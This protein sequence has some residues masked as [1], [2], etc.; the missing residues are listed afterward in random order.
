M[1]HSLSLPPSVKD[2]GY[3]VE[4]FPKK[5]RL[6]FTHKKGEVGW[7][8]FYKR[9][10]ITHFHSSQTILILSFPECL[11]CVWFNTSKLFIH[12]NTG[13]CS[14][15]NNRQ[16]FLRVSLTNKSTIKCN[17]R[18]KKSWSD[19]KYFF[20]D[21]ANRQTCKQNLTV[22]MI[23]YV[24]NKLCYFVL[25]RISKEIFIKIRWWL[26]VVYQVL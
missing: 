5:V 8:L 10:N 6:Y 18:T 26:Y 7:R 19:E 9:G 23:Q 24:W 14:D 17:V 1:Y 25:L 4:I 22:Y 11:V 12:C 16:P 2:G 21:L 3:V 15:V 13:T 20:T